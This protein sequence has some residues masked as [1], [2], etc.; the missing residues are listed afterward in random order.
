[1]ERKLIKQGGGGYT[2]YLPKKWVDE[3]GFR[4]GDTITIN[5]S[6][7]ALVVT[8]TSKKKSS[9]VIELDTDNKKDI[10]HFVTHLYRR[11]YD[12]I[13]FK[14]TDNSTNKEIRKLTTSLLLG[15]SVVNQDATSCTIENISE[16][17]DEKYDALVRRSFLIVKETLALLVQD[18]MKQ[19]YT[20]MDQM[21]DLKMQQDQFIICCRRLIAKKRV[22]V[23]TELEW[24][25]L[26][27]VMHINHSLFYLYTYCNKNKPKLSKNTIQLIRDLAD[28]YQLYYNA[29]FKKDV[30]C[31]HK[32][33]RLK[34]TY[35]FGRCYE[36][37]ERARG[38]ETI[39]LS[40]VREVFRLIH[41]ATGPVL[42]LIME[43]D[44]HAK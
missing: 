42:S 25:M 39:V 37:I 26:G 16:P 29:H 13:T 34:D 7:N 44:G 43:N 22:E 27:Q 30:K 21:N 5:Q 17:T 12:A 1:V 6:A 11:G 18:S 28:Y 19:S 10:L 8:A 4:E 24:E 3:R 2:I 23:G 36:Y 38:V 31:V 9:I 41:V 35:Q 20:H 33:H 14:N 40:S 15:F 32:I